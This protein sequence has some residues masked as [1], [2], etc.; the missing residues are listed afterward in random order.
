MIMLD[1]DRVDVDINLRSRGRRVLHVDLFG[2]A[3]LER[4]PVD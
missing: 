4:Q 3:K 2:I 1:V